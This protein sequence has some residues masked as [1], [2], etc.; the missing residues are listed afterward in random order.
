M[1]DISHI[2]AVQYL[3][4]VFEEEIK[5][6]LVHSIIENVYRK[7]LT[8]LLEYTFGPTRVVW[9]VTHPHEFAMQRRKY[10]C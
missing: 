8:Y 4:P 6:G 3:L 5:E 9:G 7:Y 2:Y 10:N 1:W